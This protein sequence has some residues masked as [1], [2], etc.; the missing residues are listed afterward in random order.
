MTLTV[1]IDNATTDELKQLK[2]QIENKIAEI[3]KEQQRQRDMLMINTY[4]ICLIEN[5]KILLSCN[6]RINDEKNGLKIFIDDFLKSA[7]KLLWLKENFLTTIS[8]LTLEIGR[9][10]KPMSKTV[11]D[12]NDTLFLLGEFLWSL[13]RLEVE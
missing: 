1:N 7:D 5:I 12:L 11:L 8:F 2:E 9:Q 4:R 13:E 3:E 6:P 10:Y